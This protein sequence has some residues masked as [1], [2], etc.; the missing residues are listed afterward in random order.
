VTLT[1]SPVQVIGQTSGVAGRIVSPVADKDPWWHQGIRRVPGR[2]P[3]RQ[4]RRMAVLRD[5]PYSSLSFLVVI[6]GI[7][8]LV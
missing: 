8:S 4:E 3:Q 6:N 7:H 5:D 1:E 2:F